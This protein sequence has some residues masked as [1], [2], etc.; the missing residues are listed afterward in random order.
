M[1]EVSAEETIALARRSNLFCI[2]NREAEASSR[3]PGVSWTRLGLQKDISKCRA[4]A[5]KLN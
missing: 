4:G 3:Q 1:F 2:L 5:A